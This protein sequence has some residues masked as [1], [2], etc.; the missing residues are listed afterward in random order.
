MQFM[1]N[2]VLEFPGKERWG[3]PSAGKQEGIKNKIIQFGDKEILCLNP[4]VKVKASLLI[5]N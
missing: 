2:T 5:W 4:F 3:H 1:R